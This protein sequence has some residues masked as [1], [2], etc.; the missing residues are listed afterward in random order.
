MSEAKKYTLEEAHRPMAVMF[1]GQTWELLEKEARTPDEDERMLHAAHASLYHWLHAGTKLHHQRGEWLCARVYTTLG[2]K[3]A[4]LRHALRCLQLTSTHSDLMEDFDSAFAY[5]CVARAQRLNGN[6]AEAKNYMQ[7]ASQAGEL[8]ANEE[9]K[10][11][12][13]EEFHGGEWFNA[14]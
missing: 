5:E 6:Y 8:I 10:R 13:F 7:Q 14:K 4:S 9:D 11:I 12:F 3:E 1:H 2:I